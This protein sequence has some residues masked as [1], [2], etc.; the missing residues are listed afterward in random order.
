[1]WTLLVTASIAAHAGDLAPRWDPATPVTYQTQTFIQVP[2]GFRFY[3]LN[4][5]DARA[6]ETAAAGTFTCTGG[7]Q[8]K[9]FDVTCT[10]DEIKLQGSAV[11]T[12]QQ[13]LDTIFAQHEETLKGATVELVLRP[14]GHIKT[15]DLE[16]V[17]KKYERGNDVHEQLRQLLRRV[18]APLGAQLPKN[19]DDPGKPWRHKG[20]PAYFDLFVTQGTDSA[21]YGTTGGSRVDYGIVGQHDGRTLI[22][23]AGVANVTTVVEREAGGGL[24]INLK[25]GGV[26]AFDAAAGQIDYVEIGLSGEY[27]ANATQVGNRTAYGFAAQMARVHADGSVGKPPPSEG[28]RAAT[29]E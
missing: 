12:E 14:D 19:G 4:N 29:P 23:Y 28:G 22:E 11:A 21:T 5:L 2:N 16:G 15:L 17:E 13:K 24:G 20:Q 9:G 18:F 1:M 6:L 25:G 7:P 26:L 10:I 8:G 3:G 27:N